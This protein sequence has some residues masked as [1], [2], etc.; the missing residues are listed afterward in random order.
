MDDKKIY[1]CPYCG[2]EIKKGNAWHVKRCRDEYIKNMQEEE[3]SRIKDLYVTQK[4]SLVQ[5]SK[6]IGLPYTQLQ[7]ILPIIGIELRNIKE[8]C[9]TT[10]RKK[11]YEKTMMEHFG[12]K[13]NFSKECS[14]RKEWE[15]RLL[16][17]EGI[18]NVFQRKEVIEK[19][20][21]T[22]VEKYG[23]EGLKYQRSKG[24]DI[25]YYIEKYGKIEGRKEWKRVCYEK[26]KSGRIEYY[27]E[28][29]GEKEG[30]KLWMEKIY[31]IT[32]C[33]KH[34]NGLNEKCA[35]LLKKN[36][37]QYEVE[38]MLP[39]ETHAFR[40][41]FKINNLLLEL[42]G[43]YWHC[44]P[45]RYMPNDLVRFPNN[46]FILAK[47][48]WE[49]DREKINNA[50]EKGFLIEVIWEDEFSEKKLLEIIKKNNYGNC[51]N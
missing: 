32:K 25:N 8:A 7:R 12:T 47:D 41:D 4:K 39:S 1:K 27:V 28:K 38:Y 34:N 35:K 9:N 23:E 26:G 6:I 11:L 45:K 37:I 5:L 2:K 44:S 46:R 19:I 17:E 21:N 20:H 40:Y 29:Y 3:K 42:N 18:T 24:S 10:E 49:Y 13:H 43:T 30:Y 50:K 33:F 31:S 48:K 36:N 15:K 14:S 16:E 51:K 22:M